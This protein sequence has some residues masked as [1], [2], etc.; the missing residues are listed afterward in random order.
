MAA[1]A[2]FIAADGAFLL[3][4]ARVLQGL[5]TGAAI[6]ALSA[7]LVELSA[8]RG[9]GHAAMVNSAAPTFGLAAGGLGASLL[10]QYGPAP[11]RLVYWLI[12]AALA[13]SALLVAKVR[14]T[15]ERR[16]GALAS[17]RPHVGLPPQARS[18]FV[19]VAPCLIAL[20]ALS[21]FYLS[22]APGLTT[23]IAHS[24]NL[25]WGGAV[26]FLPMCSGGAAVVVCK[27]LAARNAMIYGCIGLLVGVALT[28]TA[29]VTATIALF[30]AGSIIAGAG[31]GL[32]FL[33]AFRS[34]IAHA[35]PSQKA[36]M[37]AVIY[38][39]SYFAFSL[40]IITA[41]VA[42]TRYGQHDVALVLSAAIAA[43]AAIGTLA[44]LPAPNLHLRHKQSTSPSRADLPPCPGTVPGCPDQ[45]QTRGDG[46]SPKR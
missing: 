18:T 6:G 40:P 39:V 7:A 23:K 41:G 43:L 30:I 11:M 26:I 5:A 25:A 1:I 9:P 3:G 38:I 17:L 15:G 44:G 46:P 20:W 35:A 4:T 13:A 27:A 32:S 22:L 34:L 45:A 16:H 10:V 42:I 14:E 37:I 36:E 28:F 31:F 33:G 21:G 24:H 12:L 29:I 2:C 8:E 19:R